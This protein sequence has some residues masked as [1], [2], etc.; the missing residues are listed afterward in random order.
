[1]VD[2]RSS[3]KQGQIDIVELLYRFRFGNRRL[4][5]ESLSIKAGSSL[6]EKSKGGSSSLLA[7]NQQQH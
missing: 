6:Y 2:K 7:R 1:M 4:I 3:L 5:A